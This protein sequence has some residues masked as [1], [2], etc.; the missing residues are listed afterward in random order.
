MLLDGGELPKLWSILRTKH[1][2]RV[3]F[4]FTSQ[5]WI[6]ISFLIHTNRKGKENE[7][8]WFTVYCETDLSGTHLMDVDSWTSIRSSIISH[9]KLSR[10]AI[11]PIW[12]P[13]LFACLGSICQRIQD[14]SK[15]LHSNFC[16]SCESNA[17]LCPCTRSYEQELTW[18]R[19]MHWYIFDKKIFLCNNTE[20]ERK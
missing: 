3:L 13:V 18:S 10:E 19:G 14:M 8:R 4:Y 9:T 15:F 12:K 17:I 2:E 20:W 1:N 7:W 5:N 6:A 11:V 16:W